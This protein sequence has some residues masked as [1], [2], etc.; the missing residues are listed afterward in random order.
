MTKDEK[1]YIIECLAAEFGEY[2]CDEPLRESYSGRSMY[3]KTCYG[4]VTDR[5]DEL[6]ERAIEQGITGASTDNMGLST[7]VYW[8]SVTAD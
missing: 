3:G 4:I 6:I 7:I 8:K 5:P 2:G 1:I